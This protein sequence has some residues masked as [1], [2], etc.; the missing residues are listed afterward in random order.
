[1]NTATVFNMFSQHDVCLE[2]I[3]LATN[4]FNLYFSIAMGFTVF[5]G[6]HKKKTGLDFKEDISLFC[7]VLLLKKLDLSVVLRL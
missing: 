4:Q 6:L 2:I 7:L 3:I 5:S 1:M